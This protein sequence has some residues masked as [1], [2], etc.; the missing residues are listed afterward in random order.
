MVGRLDKET[1]GLIILTNDGE[2]IN[3]LTHPRHRVAKTYWVKIDGRLDKQ[4]QAAL[5]KGMYLAEGKARATKVNVLYTSNKETILEIELRQGINRQVRRMFA[6]MDNRVRALRR[7]A[8][9]GLS[10]PGLKTGKYRTLTRTEVDQ[11]YRAAGKTVEGKGTS[12]AARRNRS[13]RR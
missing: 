13:L 6:R 1:E 9:G 5:K 2:L 10:D 12:R 11:L 8:I 7:I 4:D 3:L